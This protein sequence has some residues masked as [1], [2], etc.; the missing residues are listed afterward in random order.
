MF[1]IAAVVALVAWASTASAQVAFQMSSNVRKVRSTGTAEAVGSITLTATTAGNISD[2][3]TIQ[4]DFGVDI[5]ADANIDGAPDPNL[6]FTSPGGCD[7]DVFVD[8]ID[9]SVLI[10]EFDATVCAVG[11]AIVIT[12]LRVNA[13]DAGEGATINA[14]AQ[15]TVPAGQPP[16]TFF[17]VS[18]VPVAEVEDPFQIR[19]DSGQTILTCAANDFEALDEDDLTDDEMDAA[20]RVRIEENFNQA[21]SDATDE[22]GYADYGNQFDMTF[23][24]TFKDVP[25]D[26]NIELIDINLDTPGGLVIAGVAEGDADDAGGD[27]EFEFDITATASTGANE[28]IELIFAVT[29]ADAIDSVNGG[30]DVDLGIEY[31]AGT[32]EDG[33]VPEFVDNE[34]EEFAFGVTDCLTRL[35]LTWAVANVAGYDTGTVFAN[36]SEDDLAYGAEDSDGAIAQDGNCTLTGYP[37]AGGNPIQFTTPTITAGRTHAMVLSST[38]GFNGFAGYILTVCHFL[39]AHAFAFISNNYGSTAAPNGFQGLEWNVVLQG[40]RTHEDGESL[41]K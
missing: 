34:V 1:A 4:L 28:E 12:G 38:T 14:A 8:D 18:T 26:V 9:G 37:A 27:I 11:D 3:S 2:L 5:V 22:T 7:D 29:T 16:I 10:L 13:N 15:A 33:E 39:N 25:E 31:V 20:V 41:G 19:V 17:I 6:T 40:T 23:T 32:V 36:T 21:F 35:E 30:G 24:L